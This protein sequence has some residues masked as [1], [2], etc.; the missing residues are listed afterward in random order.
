MMTRIP[1]PLLLASLLALSLTACSTLPARGQRPAVEFA[2]AATYR[3]SEQPPPAIQVPASNSELMILELTTE[4]EG[5]Q[6]FF[7]GNKRFLILPDD[8]RLLRLHCRY[9]IY[10]HQGNSGGLSDPARL[11]PGASTLTIL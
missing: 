7:Q 1:R 3:F 11:F 6:E 10:G 2:V 9:L 4:P 8:C 5:L